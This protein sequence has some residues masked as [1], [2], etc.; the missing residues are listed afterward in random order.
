M[1]TEAPPGHPVASL[2]RLV[3]NSDV[4]E[5]GT[6]DVQDCAPLDGNLWSAPGPVRDL[7]LEKVEPG[8]VR[9]SWT[10]PLDAGTDGILSYSL[11]LSIDVDDFGL[12]Q[13][14]VM[15]TTDTEATLP[16]QSVGPLEAYLV[17]VTNGCGSHA[18]VGSDGETRSTGTCP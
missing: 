13:C 1:L 18:G 10:A 4:D 17:R 11:L 12:V 5:D 6:L 9:F 8:S 2:A 16:G 14:P 7:K 3:T 15:A